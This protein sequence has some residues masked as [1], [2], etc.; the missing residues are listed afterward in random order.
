MI[1]FKLIQFDKGLIMKRVLLVLAISVSALSAGGS[2][3]KSRVDEVYPLKKKSFFPGVHGGV[4]VD[5]RTNGTTNVANS[6]GYVTKRSGDNSF[7]IYSTRTDV[8]DK[9]GNGYGYNVGALYGRNFKS[10]LK[11]IILE[12]LGL[13]AE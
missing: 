4:G 9:G 6:S 2:N 1:Y 7:T 10:A 5:Y 13:L 11:E 8:W 3:S 12:E